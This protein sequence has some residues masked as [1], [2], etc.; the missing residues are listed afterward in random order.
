MDTLLLTR[1]EAFIQDCRTK[2]IVKDQAKH[3]KGT[4]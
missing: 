4:Y 2:C 3:K 1:M